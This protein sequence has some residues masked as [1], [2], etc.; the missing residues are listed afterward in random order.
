M[1]KTKQNQIETAI[2]ELIDQVEKFF[3]TAPL[4]FLD[5]KGGNSD[6]GNEERASGTLW[7]S[8]PLVITRENPVEYDKLRGLS[9]RIGP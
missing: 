2:P 9:A 8:A 1:K 7:S 3:S 5:I 4:R 6:L